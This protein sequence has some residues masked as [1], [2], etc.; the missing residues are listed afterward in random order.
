MRK[1]GNYE[2]HW[3]TSEN[4]RNVMKKILNEE[5][6]SWK[7]WRK[8]MRGGMERE[9]SKWGKWEVLVNDDEHVRRKDREWKRKREKNE[10]TEILC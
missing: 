9:S 5:E 7:R 1:V 8:A 2:E 6:N 3:R 10:E 4:E